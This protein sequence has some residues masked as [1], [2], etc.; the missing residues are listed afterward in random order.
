MSGI[1][2]RWRWFWGIV[3]LCTSLFS[4][5]CA[6]AQQITPDGTLPNNSNVS[7]IGNTFNITGG[8]QAGSNLF[9]SFGLFSVPTGTTAFFNNAADI[10]NIINRVTGGSISNI[11]GLIRAN[12]AAN[13]FLINPSGIVFGQNASLNVGGSFLA[14]TATSFN[15]ADG[16]TFSAIAPQSTPLLTISVPIGLQFGQN[17]AN[18]Q[19]QGS[20]LQGAPNKTLGLVG[21]NLSLDNSI[22]QIPGGR[23]ELG[24]VADTGTVGLNV[25]G[26]D[27]S[28]NF[29]DG[30]AKQDVSLSNRANVNVLAG[31]G[32]SIAINA[33]NLNISGAG[34]EIRAG[35]APG[36]GSPQSQA[37]N[38]EINATEAIIDGSLV[39]NAIQANAVGQGSDIIIKTGSL[40]VSNGARIETSS[41]G[42]GNAG[43]LLI[44]AQGQVTFINGGFGFT[45]LEATGVGNGGNLQIKAGSVL[46]TNNSQLRA[47]T[48][49]QGNSGNV[50]I[51][52]RDTAEVSNEGFIFSQVEPGGIGNGGETSITTG[53][54]SVTNGGILSASTLGKGDAGRINIEARDTASFNR[55]GRAFTTVEGQGMGNGNDLRIRARSLSV[56]D[57]SFL[58]ANTLGRGNAGN[59][60]IEAGESVLFDRGTATSSVEK[61]A[62]GNGGETRITTGSLSVTNSATLRAST[63]GEGDA[64]RINI[65]ARDTASFDRDGG[66]FTTVEAEGMGNGNDLRI[67]ARSLS[68]TDG[69]F[70]TANTVGQG[71]AGNVIIETGESVL[72]DR[73]TATST[74][75]LR[76]FAVAQGNGGTISISTGSLQLA[77]QAQ[78]LVNSYGRVGNAGNIKINARDTVSFSNNSE[79]F[80][81][82]GGGIRGSAG[83][84]DI[85]TGS[86][87]V[88]SGSII[89]S[90]SFGNGNGGNITIKARDVVSFLTEAGAFSNVRFGA[91]GNSGDINI[92]T[93]SLNT[94]DGSFLAASI[95]GTGNSGNVRI[96][97]T[98][99]IS[100]EGVN[101]S[102][103]AGGIYSEV[104]TAEP[105]R[106]GNIDIKTRSLTVRNGARLATD[107]NGR[108]DAGSINID[109]TD[110]VTFDGIGSNQ[111]ISGAY[112]LVFPSG[113]GNADNINITTRNLSLSNGAILTAGTLG[114]GNAGTININA[115]DSVTISGTGSTRSSTFVGANTQIPGDIAVTSSNVTGIFVQSE[116]TG[117][118]GDIIVNSPKINLNNQGGLIAQSQSGN[119]GNIK[120]EVGDLLLLRGASQISTT[121][122]TAQQGGDGGNIT[123][124]SPNGFIVAVPNENS[125]ISANAFRG[126]GGK[127][128]ITASGIYGIEPRPRL[129]ELS[130]ITASSELGVQGTIQIN[131]PNVDPNQGLLQLP[132]GIVNTP[133]LVSS[134]CAAFDN[135]GSE[136]IVTGRGGLPLSPDD[137]LS[138]DVVW[139]DSRLSAITAQQSRTS[140]A[141]PAKPKAIE[142]VPATGWVF[143]GK[144][145][146]TLISSASEGTDF[147]SPPTCAK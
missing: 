10:Q 35:I 84:I 136:F 100:L 57:G 67:R 132:A 123:I 30:I 111:R 103:F 24:S 143:N 125:D 130:D 113:I 74:V 106:G 17:P 48:L 138:S 133:I 129:T 46:V 38:I 59:V 33:R 76:D 94:A 131:T 60:I 69:S 83:N 75:G 141:K 96:T 107:T 140:P 44:D 90:E 28:L 54:L 20:R 62:I 82:L 64:G 142:I 114:Q 8:T 7:K 18:I 105:G 19:V 124:N 115:S 9:H 43:N 15:F 86:L 21:G 139:T 23:V 79:I 91:I 73:G 39:S 66:A 97:A 112:S 145:E 49:G 16:T 53:S 121:A 26:S 37:G 118:A 52:A 98:D 85:S 127:V 47:S 40:K 58:T 110:F 70:L 95:L 27:L 14:T 120:L 50:I 147:V 3:G 80:S 104:A 4:P 134:S 102:G 92:T 101:R 31:G 22:L 89:S 119:G 77:N 93:G 11:D 45:S 78:L 41:F 29:P 42:Q 32:G 116:S 63:A 2:N 12:G 68:V 146:V 71:N 135:K 55:V 99:S 87:Q 61:G 144:G 51:N 88:K 108:G 5:N 109:A 137:F 72:F 56:T 122:G 34:T 128:D 81:Q 65:E 1:S 25:N 36:L 126:Q 6:L 117:R 13:L